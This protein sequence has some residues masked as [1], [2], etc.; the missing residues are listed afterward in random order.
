MLGA[1]DSSVKKK[2]WRK[3][4]VKAVDAGSAENGATGGGD[5]KS[6]TKS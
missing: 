3:P 6:A 5:A 1:G 4:E 2:I